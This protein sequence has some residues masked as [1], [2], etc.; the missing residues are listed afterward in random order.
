MKRRHLTSSSL[1]LCC[2]LASMPLHAQDISQIAKSDPL[3][4][5][6]SIGT[7]NTYYYSSVGN[8]YASPL[9]NTFYANLNI[10]LYGFNMPFALYY[11]NDNMAFSHPQLTF[12]LNPRYKHWTG[13]L[14][15]GSMSYS[16]YVMS[17]S[18]NGIGVEYDDN[19]RWR[20]G[21]FYGVL[22]RAVNDDPDDPLARTPQ[23]KRIGWGAK[24]GYGSRS[25]YIDLYF[26][27]AYDR[28]K[29]IDE[30]WQR[31]VSPQD[32]IVVG[33]RAAVQPLPC[34]S[35]SANAAASIFSTDTRAEAVPDSLFSNGWSSV[36]D[37]RYTSLARF[38][39][40]ISANL[41]LRG[42]TASAFYRMVQP[43]YTSLGTYYMSN[44]YHSLGLSVT[45]SLPANVSL[46]AMFSGQADNLSRRQL[47]TTRG[48]VY[49]ATVGTRLLN[50]LNL[51]ASYNGYTQ[52]QGDGTARVND[53]TRVDRVMQS[54]TLTPSVAFDTQNLTHSIA[55]SAS[56]TENRD[57]NRFSTGQSD[58]TSVALGLS[59][60]L[61]VKP[62]DTNFAATLNYQSSRGY[63]TRYISRIASLN[64]NRSFL[65]EKSLNLSATLNMIYNE[66]KGRSKSLSL[67][68]DLSASYTLKKVHMFSL[69]ASFNK[70]GDVNI[71]KRR[72][73]LDATDITASLNY[74]YTFSLLEIKRGKRQEVRGE[75]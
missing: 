68:A 24:V 54:F 65:K 53:T 56:Y 23:Y 32:N 17:M 38:A 3:V 16:S 73:S 52:V 55:L 21:M 15:Q 61:G 33:L 57:R 29:S 72:S 36:F 71:T 22:R 60:G 66:V 25:N 20:F 14:G 27:K 40:D 30:R 64:A 11:T 4:I 67:G 74:N 34:L 6:G 5:T 75:R 50:V 70:Y 7:N 28:L 12:S 45:A 69:A 1:W 58:V 35:V 47:Y 63:Q 43:D 13:Y 46:S 19:R 31:Q 42:F 10:S 9:S 59:Y 8:G 26:L 49:S 18:F 2:L 39:G 62:W 48:Y 37:T 41:Y 51:S 44:N